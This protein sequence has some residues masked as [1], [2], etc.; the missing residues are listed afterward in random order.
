MT[1]SRF[2]IVEKGKTALPHKCITCGTY[3][4]PFLDFDCDQI[5]F[6][7]IY[8]CRTCFQEAARVFGFAAVDRTKELRDLQGKYDQLT[9]DYRELKRD[10][11]DF[12]R[13]IGRYPVSPN[14]DSTIVTTENL[15]RES[16][17]QQSVNSESDESDSGGQL[18][19]LRSH[20][21]AVQRDEPTD[22]D[23]FIDN[24]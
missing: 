1:D 22:V 11:V 20:A 12:D 17:S 8:F 6:G 4:G 7:V 15:Q 3:R 18:Q 5:D 21:T 9:R 24:L 2:R 19:H 23:D 14:P 10:A 13:I 16:A